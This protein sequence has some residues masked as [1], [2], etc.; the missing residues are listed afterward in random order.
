MPNL[1][2]TDAQV[3]ELVKQLPLNR[4]R[5]LL[6]ELAKEQER[7]RPRRPKYSEEEL[8]RLCSDRG[9]N[10]D[11]LSPDDREAFIDYLA[12][13]EKQRSHDRRNK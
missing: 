6:Q 3:I 8:R 10:W 7:S 1:S 2:L 9:H 11:A 12:L 4:K 13:G 5:A